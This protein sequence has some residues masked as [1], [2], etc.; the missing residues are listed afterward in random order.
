MST[1]VT[2]TNQVKE[3]IFLRV[4]K[5]F[6][7]TYSVLYNQ[8]QWTKQ[9]NLSSANELEFE[10]YKENPISKSLKINSVKITSGPSDIGSVDIQEEVEVP[11]TDPKETVLKIKVNWATRRGPKL[12]PENVEVGVKE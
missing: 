1:N 10:F 6:K 11:G 2:V 9:I 5:P 3:N 12:P 8:N 7:A 4:V